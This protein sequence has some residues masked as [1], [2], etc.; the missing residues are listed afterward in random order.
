MI[1]N[2]N[3]CCLQIELISQRTAIEDMIQPTL[4]VSEDI[5][6]HAAREAVW[7]Y[8]CRLREWPRWRPDVARATWVQGQL[9][10]E[11]AQFTIEPTHSLPQ[12]VT[13]L[14]RMVVP[15]DTTV[16]ENNS[17]GPGV[18]YSLHLADQVGGCK[19]TLRCTFHGWGSLLKR[20]TSVAEKAKLQT[21][22]VGLKAA[23]ERP[24]TRR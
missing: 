10:Q 14:I 16:W 5:Y 24:E 7:E 13:Y 17:P 21:L 15:D 4:Q 12:S 22:L 2:S 20:L 11:G 23:L 1:Y 18:V 6:V 9:W 8:F 3:Q 19:V